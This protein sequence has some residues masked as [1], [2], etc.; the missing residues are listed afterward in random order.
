M[1]TSNVIHHMIVLVPK[2]P[3]VVSIA[4]EL[5]AS[6]SLQQERNGI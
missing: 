1:R 2:A 6:G 4:P 3:D 5:D